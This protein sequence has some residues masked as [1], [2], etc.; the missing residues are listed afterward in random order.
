MKK[1]MLVAALVAAVG[2]GCKKKN[3]EEGTGGGGSAEMGSGGM[4]GGSGSAA[5]AGGSGSAAGSGGAAAPAKP[6]TPDEIA[7]RFDQCWGY[8]NNNKLDDMKGCFGADSTQDAPGSG[9]PTVTGA[10]AIIANI[11]NFKDAFPDMK[12][13]G[14]VRIVSGHN[15]A[16]MTF[17]SGTNTGTMKTPMGDM[18][19]TKAK[20]GLVMAQMGEIGDDGKAKH[21]SDLNDMGELMG[22]M[23]PDPKHP[24]RPA[25]DKSPMAPQVL[26]SKDDA[27]EKANIE[28]VKKGAEAFSKHDAKAFGDML[29][30]DAKWSE[31][32][33]PKDMDKKTTLASMQAFWKAFSDAK[34]VADKAYAAGDFVMVSANME[35]TNDGDFKE[36]G[37]K[38]TGKHMSVPHMALFEIKGGKIKNAWI[39]ENSMAMAMQLGLM[40]PPGAAPAGEKKD[41]KA[42]E[43]K[44]DKKPAGDKKDDKKP[45]PEKKG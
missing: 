11:K 30:D 4:A 8:F 35:G 18:P 39:V 5:M 7:K 14:I 27:A 32:A 34:I 26:I 24:V 15:I 20:V 10:D 29:A 21:L 28:L 19:P 2:F 40:P 6:M 1:M 25:M 45:A 42:G 12:G 36:M 9:M 33:M 17:V 37:I 38:K 41:E 3:K 43:K 44:D 31:S 13:E 23:K 16:G 22:Q